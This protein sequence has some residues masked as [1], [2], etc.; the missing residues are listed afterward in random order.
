MAECYADYYEDKNKILTMLEYG[1]PKEREIALGSL[2]IH[3]G[4]KDYFD[5]TWRIFLS[6]E[7]WEVKKYALNT[8]CHFAS[9]NQIWEIIEYILQNPD[10]IQGW[11]KE[12]GYERTI[13]Q[14]LRL[15][16]QRKE[17]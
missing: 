4:K 7:H 17:I 3:F 12:T 10:K 16:H 1:T 5:L 11:E 15:R 2:V 6:D 14:E 8:A 9:I 13:L